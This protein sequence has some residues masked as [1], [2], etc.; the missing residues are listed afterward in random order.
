[1]LATSFWN[2]VPPLDMVAYVEGIS[3]DS[4]VG[5]TPAARDCEV[6]ALCHLHF[7]SEGP[8]FMRDLLKTPANIRQKVFGEWTDDNSSFSEEEVL[9]L[10]GWIK[11]WSFSEEVKKK[12]AQIFSG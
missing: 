10:R 3:E 7:V 9:K 4:P 11:P 1:M 2:D 8:E 6:Q 12:L 5:P